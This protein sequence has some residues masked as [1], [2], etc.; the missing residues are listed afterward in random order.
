MF[1]NSIR[2]SVLLFY[3]PTLSVQH[4][5][6]ASL[7]PSDNSISSSHDH[8]W[9]L[10][11]PAR[12]ASFPCWHLAFTVREQTRAPLWFPVHELT[13]DG[14]MGGGG[15]GARWE[16]RDMMC[17]YQ[18]LVNSSVGHISCASQVCSTLV[19]MAKTLLFSLW[20]W[21]LL[22]IL[23]FH[24]NQRVLKLFMKRSANF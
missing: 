22:W 8:R 16:S 12:C 18:W 7:M 23:T 6:S 15:R 1:Y 14:G 3:L 9:H 17:D 11:T 13:S 2:Q 20:V 10:V 4:G 24:Q 21:L 19:R 5:T